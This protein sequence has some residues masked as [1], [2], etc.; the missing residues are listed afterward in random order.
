[1]Y[2]SV[3]RWK[4][5]YRSKSGRKPP[6]VGAT[7]IRLCAGRGSIWPGASAVTS[8]PGI[9]LE[10]QA[11]RYRSGEWFE[12]QHSLTRSV[13]VSGQLSNQDIRE[14][15]ESLWALTRHFN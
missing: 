14:E 13:E 2:P 4:C 12:S 1:M 3:A 11:T 9:V 10:A 15:I 6:T 8:P 5:R 7:H